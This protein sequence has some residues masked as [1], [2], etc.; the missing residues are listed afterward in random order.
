[1]GLAAFDLCGGLVAFQFRPTRE[2]YSRSPLQ[3]R[4][5]FALVHLQPFLLPVL[6]EGSWRQATMR[7]ATA[8]TSTAVLE[9]FPPRSN[10]CRVLSNCA[11]AILSAVDLACGKSQQSWFGPIYLMKVIGGHASIRRL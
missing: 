11:A 3:A 8:V 10:S 5:L 1:M 4:M 6:G 2:K 7:Y 9:R